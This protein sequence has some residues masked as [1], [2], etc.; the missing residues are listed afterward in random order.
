MAHEL[1]LVSGKKLQIEE[2][3]KI[4]SGAVAAKAFKYYT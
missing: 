2:I 1:R 4:I 3:G